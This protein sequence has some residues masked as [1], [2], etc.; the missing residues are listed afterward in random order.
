MLSKYQKIIQDLLIEIKNHK[1][2]PGDKFYSESEIKKKYDVSSITAVKALN[3]LTNM[4]Y[5]YRI[6]G[7]G[8]FLSKSKV[9]QTVKFTDIEFHDHE[10]EEIE[11]LSVNV[12]NAPEILQELKLKPEDSYVKIQRIRTTNGTPFIVHVTHLPMK[13]VKEPIL[14]DINEYAS[15]YEK[16]RKD[17]NIDLFSLA[18]VETNEVMFP[19][20]PNILNYLNLS[21]REPV[22]KQ[23]KHTYLPDGSVAEYIVS[24]KH[25]KA[26]K[27]KIEVEV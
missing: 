4:G 6:Q 12:E 1:F 27:T 7:K 25:W 5:L 10:S 22:V 20:D 15:I 8:T 9:S 16:I 23:I 2:V 18:S 11:V 24:F 19:E 17:F 26:F 13:L 14:K 21:F 3:E